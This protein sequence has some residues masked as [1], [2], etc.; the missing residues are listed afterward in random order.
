MA[1][2]RLVLAL[3]GGVDW[4]L[5]ALPERVACCRA[6]G[7]FDAPVGEWVLGALIGMHRELFRCRYLAGEALAQ[8]V[9]DEYGRQC[10]T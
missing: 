6:A 10:A 5:P 7:V 3:T 1:G 4:L 8:R 2:L 9:E